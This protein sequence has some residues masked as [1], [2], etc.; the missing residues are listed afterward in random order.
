M[1]YDCLLDPIGFNQCRW[2]YHNV[3]DLRKVVSEYAA[4]D[5]PL[6]TMWTDIDY[7]DAYRIFTTDPVHFPQTEFKQFVD[8]LHQNQQHYIPIVR[9]SIMT[10]THTHTHT[11]SSLIAV[12]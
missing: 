10:D 7:M 11:H 1:A 2:G 8:T 3:A 9:Y 12:D 5:L 4:H 6:D